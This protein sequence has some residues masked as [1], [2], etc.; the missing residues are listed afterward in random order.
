VH[1]ALRRSHR[2]AGDARDLFVGEAERVAEYDGEPLVG[3]EPG[4]RVAE[5]PPEV[6][7]RHRA[8][9]VAVVAGG[10]VGQGERLRLTQPLVCDSIA[11][12]IDDES[13][14][15]RRELR[16]ASELTQSRAELDEGLL[17]RVARV[18]DVPDHLG[19]D[20]L[21]TR[22]IALDE[23]VERSPVSVRRL[24]DE[25]H[26]AE[27]SVL[28]PT[29]G[30]GV[31]L[32][33]TE[34]RGGGLHGGV[35]VALRTMSDSLAP[36][37]VEPLL[38]G[39]FGRPYLYQDAC[40]STQEL[41]DRALEEGAV[42][43]CDE[44]TAGRGRLGRAWKAPPG[45]AILCSLILRPPP[46]RPKAELSLVGG[47]AAAETVERATA[48]AAQIKWPNDVMMNRRKV[49]GVLAEAEG[50]SV[51]LGIGLNVNQRLEELPGE[52]TSPPAS[53]LTVDGVRRDRAPILADLLAA[54]ERAYDV[55][56]AKGLSGLYDGLGARDFLR[57]RRIVVDGRSGYGV[58]IDREGRLEAVLEGERC[59]IESGEVLFER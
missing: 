56:R 17:G 35:S 23:R 55:W 19:R 9:R 1:V 51:I 5:L 22:R 24:H 42:A 59:L 14:K 40:E 54:L 48:L 11:T 27:L 33:E 44:Q 36:E 45:T 58:A 25:V 10:L 3:R 21:H 15:P 2:H 34:R 50:D 4:K 20:P 41:L 43:V 38:A 53:L 29:P 16:F 39:R 6:G 47:L 7:E 31:L 37:A 46:G 49:A 32:G 26:V 18:L 30:E 12:R 28:V 13:V 8:R 52:A 57:G